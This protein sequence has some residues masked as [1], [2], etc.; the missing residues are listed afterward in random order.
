MGQRVTF[1][2]VLQVPE[3]RALWMAELLSTLGDQVARVSL[4]V[5]VFHDT[6]SA[7]LTGLTFALTYLPML[8]GGL[9]LSRL[10]DRFSRR[11]VMVA[12]NLAQ[13]VLIGV[14]AVPGVPL[15]LLYVLLAM[16]VM[17]TGPFNAAQLAVLPDLVSGDKYVTAMAI[18]NVTTYTSQLAGFAGGG[19][20]LTAVNPNLGLAIDAVTFAVSALLLRTGMRYRPPAA[21]GGGTATEKH[22]LLNGFH[23]IWRDRRTRMLIGV[24]ALAFFYI[25][26]EAL[27]APYAAQLGVGPFGVGL[28]MAAD[29]VG[30]V[31]G[32][33]LFARL[34]ETARVRSVAGLGIAAGLPLV[35]CALHPHLVVAL[36]M[37]AISGASAT[38]YTMQA[39]TAT[40][41]LLPASV[42]AQG[43]GFGS[44][45]IQSVQGIGALLAGI[46]GAAFQPS[47]GIAVA[48]AAGV[49]VAAFLTVAWRRV[50]QPYAAFAAQ[51]TAGSA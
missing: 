21:A 24:G 30:A 41:L 23:V 3:F 18:R 15:W 35:V 32:S 47:G 29:P 10:G 31:A 38:I 36:V 11:E 1:G 46:L 6:G 7:V 43:V 8:I 51:T 25:A 2:S 37:F 49:A 14:M 17:A 50:A 39:M 5:L 34:S 33:V 22:S 12:A 4:A 16:A 42:R 9:F 44:A 20:L 40:T 13:A 28:I 19:L 45:V 26:P 48:G 27:A